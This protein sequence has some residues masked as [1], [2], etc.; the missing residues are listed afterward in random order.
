MK[1]HHHVK[2]KNLGSVSLIFKFGVLEY[3]SHFLSLFSQMT[4][5]VG[6]TGTMYIIAC[7]LGTV[8]VYSMETSFQIMS[9]A[10]EIHQGGS[11]LKKSLAERATILV[12]M[13][14]GHISI[15]TYTEVSL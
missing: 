4:P 6:V 5:V 11:K 10:V 12:S 15:L 8:R 3:S 7:V 9:S 13:A 14:K 1:I 2:P